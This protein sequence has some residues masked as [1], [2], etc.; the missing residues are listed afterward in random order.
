MFFFRLDL[1]GIAIVQGKLSPYIGADVLR[2]H[3]HVKNWV[4][5]ED[6]LLTNNLVIWN[7]FHETQ[8]SPI[9]MLKSFE[10]IP[11]VSPASHPSSI[12]S[13]LI[14]CRSLFNLTSPHLL[15]QH[16][17]LH[18]Q[19]SLP[20]NPRS[21]SCSP[22]LPAPPS[23]LRRAARDAAAR[24]ASAASPPSRCPSPAPFNPNTLR[25]PPPPGRHHPRCCKNNTLVGLY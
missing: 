9:I 22:P 14:S 1:C 18:P 25:R 4:H 17:R 3:W 13:A 6:E 16:S 21:L 11:F 19:P 20:C 7:V 24:S 10:R 2:G 15:P 8:L 5:F 23:L 12:S